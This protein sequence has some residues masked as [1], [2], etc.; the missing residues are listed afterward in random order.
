M[1]L[2]FHPEWNE[3]SCLQLGRTAPILYRAHVARSALRIPFAIQ[4]CCTNV[5]SA[6]A[7]FVSELTMN[8]WR[9]RGAGNRNRRRGLRAFNTLTTL[10]RSR[11]DAA[12]ELE[13]KCLHCGRRE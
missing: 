10:A 8:R 11:R 6:P 9:D 3:T 5:A 1:R 7:T 2:M 12:L 13:S 4:E